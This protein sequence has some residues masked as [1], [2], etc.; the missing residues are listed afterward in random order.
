MKPCS[1]QNKFPLLRRAHFLIGTPVLTV[2]DIEIVHVIDLSLLKTSSC[3]NK[4]YTNSSGILEHVVT[5]M[6]VDETEPGWTFFRE[7][8][9]FSKIAHNSAPY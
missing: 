1:D 2:P 8:P 9:V 5:A 4:A 3:D 6:K 7:P